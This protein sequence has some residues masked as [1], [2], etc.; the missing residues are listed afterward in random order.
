M[1]LKLVF[2]TAKTLAVLWHTLAFAAGAVYVWHSYRALIGKA[3][4]QKSWGGVIRQADI[5]LWL[6]GFIIIGIGIVLSGGEAYLSNP[7]LWT[8][9]NVISVWLASTQF[10]RHYALPRFRSG[11]ARPM[12]VACSVNLACWIYGAFLGVAK[13][14]AYGAVPLAVLAGG[15]AAVIFICLIT[16]FTLAGASR[17]GHSHG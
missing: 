1:T 4:P 7:K 17:L 16:T 5:H 13:G 14:L 15:F 12:L 11:E 6:S 9:V 3:S 8:K 10:L 2:E